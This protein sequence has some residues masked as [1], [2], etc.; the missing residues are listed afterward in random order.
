[1]LSSPHVGNGVVD[2]AIRCGYP[3]FT[4]FPGKACA[5]KWRSANCLDFLFLFRQGKRKQ[6]L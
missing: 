6:E 2:L 5:G 4:P 3:F 1:M